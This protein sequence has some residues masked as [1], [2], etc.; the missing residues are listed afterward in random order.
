MPV[1]YYRDLSVWQRGYSLALESYRIA[2]RLPS[3]ERFGLSAQIRSA[4]V[5]IPA[6]IAE[7]HGRVHSGD[8]L[9]HLSMARGSA[10]ELETHFLIV[11]GLG[12][13]TSADLAT[14]MRLLDEISR[15]LTKLIRVLSR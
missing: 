15:M 2:A 3:H 13:V 8:Y 10:M 4:A 11:E 14:A 5:S 6:N 12:Y 1:R 7:G 9:H